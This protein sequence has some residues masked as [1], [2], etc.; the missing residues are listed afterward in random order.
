MLRDKYS[1]S[2]YAA[3]IPHSPFNVVNA[4]V[5]VIILIVYNGVP[6]SFIAP[7]STKNVLA[8]ILSHRAI[9]RK[10]YLLVPHFDFQS[11]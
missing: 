8:V 3:N 7:H 9:D 1:S 11:S 10:K 6:L 2:T 5:N 4:I